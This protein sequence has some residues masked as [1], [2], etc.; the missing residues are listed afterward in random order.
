[1]EALPD[2]A[3][4]SDDDLRALIRRLEEEEHEISYRRRILH[5]QIDILRAEWT[6]RLHGQVQR[7]EAAISSSD[8][9]K[10]AEILARKGPPPS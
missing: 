4:L 8:L 10:L 9:E 7:G 6:A 1:V 2:L 3:T 5:G